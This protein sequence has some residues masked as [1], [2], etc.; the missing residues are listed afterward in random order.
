[1]KNEVIEKLEEVRRLLYQATMNGSSL[2]NTAVLV[3]MERDLNRL[4]EYTN[5]YLD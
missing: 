5:V 2:E 1:M 3:V 4:I